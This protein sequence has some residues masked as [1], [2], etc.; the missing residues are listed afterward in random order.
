[1][2]PNVRVPLQCVQSRRMTLQSCGDVTLTCCADTVEVYE[3]S[4]PDGKISCIVDMGVDDFMTVYRGVCACVGCG[5]G[6][7]L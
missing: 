1:M 3:G 7:R 2:P 4:P 5:A 6:G